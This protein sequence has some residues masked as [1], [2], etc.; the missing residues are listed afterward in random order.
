MIT[1]YYD[2]ARS[3]QVDRYSFSFSPFLPIFVRC[4]A[5]H[6]RNNSDIPKRSMVIF[7]SGHVHT[8]LHYLW[9]TGSNASAWRL[10]SRE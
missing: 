3:G 2:K 9:Q 1:R 7:I 4:Q 5:P 8:F 6:Q 10:N